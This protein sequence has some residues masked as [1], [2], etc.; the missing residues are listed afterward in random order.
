MTST[1]GEGSHEIVEEF[2]CNNNILHYGISYQN[3]IGCLPRTRHDYCDSR[4][5]AYFG[6][7]VNSMRQHTYQAKET[8]TKRKKRKSGQGL[9]TTI[10]GTADVTCV[11]L[12]TR[13]TLN[14]SLDV[15]QA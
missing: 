10:F 6:A 5:A 3:I 11:T 8:N 7:N 2:L 4:E 15:V 9:G 14:E 12:R 1:T 13:E